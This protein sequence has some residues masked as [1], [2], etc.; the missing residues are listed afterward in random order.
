MTGGP[1]F[2]WV[3]NVLLWAALVA[4]SAAGAWAYL[5]LNLMAVWIAAAFA[6][7]LALYAAAAVEPKH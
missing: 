2:G 6:L 5:Q 7:L 1:R 3:P 4:G